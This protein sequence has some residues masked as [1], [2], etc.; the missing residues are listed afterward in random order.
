LSSEFKA[1]FNAILPTLNKINVETLNNSVAR[2]KLHVDKFGGLNRV[3][4]PEY[5]EFDNLN[6]EFYLS[7]RLVGSDVIETYFKDYKLFVSTDDKK[8]SYTVKV[9]RDN[10]H[11]L[12]FTDKCVGDRSVREFVS[13]GVRLV[14]GE[15]GYLYTELP[16]NVSYWQKIPGD[17]VYDSNIGTMDIEVYTV[18]NTNGVS[19]PYACGFKDRKGNKQL[20]YIKKD[21]KPIN[22]VVRMLEAMVVRSYDK[23]IFYV[24][25]LARFDSRY[26]L[27][28]LG[29]DSMADYCLAPLGRGINELFS[30]RIIRQPRKGER[31]ISITLM[32]SYYIQPFSLDTLSKK[33]DKTETSMYT[34]SV[35]PHKF[36]SADNLWYRGPMPPYEYYP[37]LKQEQYNSI[38]ES[39]GLDN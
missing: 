38:S 35:F 6:R 3:H 14:Y 21:E 13:T 20:F 28:A 8:S 31:R 1:K 24:H 30:M 36:V 27:A 18:P 32:D 4:F 33:Y 7:N 2:K 17:Y 9:L 34:K 37:S 16:Y 23:N 19:L 26:I 12:T 22:V 10:V 39:F 11:K 29:E 15:R 25:N 5:R